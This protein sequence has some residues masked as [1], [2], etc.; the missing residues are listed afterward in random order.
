MNMHLI[1]SPLLFVTVTLMLVLPLPTVSARSGQ[2]SPKT[3]TGEVMDTFCANAGSHDGMMAKMPTMGR[4]K[5]TCTKKCAEIGAK[6]VLFDKAH[7]AIY[8]LENKAKIEAFAGRRVRVTGT[9]DGDTI[10]VTNVN[11]VG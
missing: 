3:F 2:A 5:D 8:K 7:N 1:R 4:D 11:A 6:Y 9:L 10:N